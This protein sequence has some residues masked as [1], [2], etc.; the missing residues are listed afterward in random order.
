M[1]RGSLSEPD[2]R[3]RAGRALRCYRTD[4]PTPDTWQVTFQVP[5]TTLQLV[6]VILHL[7][8]NDVTGVGIGAAGG[9]YEI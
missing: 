3:I 8:E 4:V 2:W 7:L 5:G 9:V 6:R 1:L